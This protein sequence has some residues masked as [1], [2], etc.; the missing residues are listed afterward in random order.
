M[1]TI[2]QND[3]EMVMLSITK[4]TELL[5]AYVN[6]EP[7]DRAGIRRQLKTMR[8][9]CDLLEQVIVEAENRERFNESPVKYL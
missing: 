3:S 6:A 5:S 7:I 1:K 4:V 9:A 2:E 8:I